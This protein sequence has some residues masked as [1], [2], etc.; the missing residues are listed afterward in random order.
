MNE[1]NVINIYQKKKK[2]SKTAKTREKKKQTRITVSNSRYNVSKTLSDVFL[3]EVETSAF[4]FDYE[5]NFL[6]DH[7]CLKLLSSPKNCA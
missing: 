7:A 4:S 1:V 2:K 5:E 3:G 6:K